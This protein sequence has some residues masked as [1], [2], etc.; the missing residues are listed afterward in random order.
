MR[1][2]AR[3]DSLGEAIVR[4]NR[5][6][7]FRVGTG[8]K[9]SDDQYSVHVLLKSRVADASITGSSNPVPLQR[10]FPPL[11]EPL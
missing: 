6:T 3:R 2:W 7:S 11:A 9:N 4:D 10:F 8:I 1:V 5:E